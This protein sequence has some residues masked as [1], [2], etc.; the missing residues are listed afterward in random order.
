MSHLWNLVKKELKELLTPSALL[1]VI[2]VTILFVAMGSFL[3]GETKDI[4]SLQRVGFV[5]YSTD[6][7]AGEDYA[8]MGID[9]VRA[10][11]QSNDYDPDDY[12]LILAIESA[13]G[14][15]AFN[16]ELYDMIQ[17]RMLKIM[18]IRNVEVDVLI[19]D[20]TLHDNAD[21]KLYEKYMEE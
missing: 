2:V 16:D 8:Q 15:D 5:D 7:G 13:Y 6:P 21:I 18:S 12:V 20:V 1:S 3:G 11:Y 19:G 10:Y 9:N 14:T 17:N 4:T